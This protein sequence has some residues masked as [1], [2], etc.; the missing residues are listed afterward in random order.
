MLH[1][2]RRNRWWTKQISWSMSIMI[3]FRI[4]R[5]WSK[6]IKIIYILYEYIIFFKYN[7]WKGSFWISWVVSIRNYSR[8]PMNWVR[9]I[10]IL[11]MSV[12]VW[13]KI[14]NNWRMRIQNCWRS[15]MRWYSS[16]VIYN[17]K[18]GRLIC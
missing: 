6:K 16:W 13:G 11:K 14:L 5:E 1:S 15:V 4:I 17:V 9:N 8:I 12:I 2:R 7:K 10:I 3:I 18:R